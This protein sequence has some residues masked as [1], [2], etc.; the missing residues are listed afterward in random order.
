MRVGVGVIL[1]VMV[2]G[3]GV[4]LGVAE[5]GAGLEVTVKDGVD[6]ITTPQG[7]PRLGYASEQ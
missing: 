6:S 4:K 2:L 7:T 1:G 5:G 3:I